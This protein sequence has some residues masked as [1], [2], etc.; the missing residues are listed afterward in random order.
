MNMKECL[1]S[2]DFIEIMA[3]EIVAC[4]TNLG[5][6]GLDTIIPE[7]M[8]MSMASIAEYVARSNSGGADITIDNIYNALQLDKD[9]FWEVWNVVSTEAQKVL[10]EWEEDE[11]LELEKMKEDEADMAAIE[12]ESA[13]EESAAEEEFEQWLEQL[14][15]EYLA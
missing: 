5:D 13:K 14:E 11:L 6:D 15:K 1:L 7:T 9:L 8:M 2:E 3:D 4:A 12:A 10:A